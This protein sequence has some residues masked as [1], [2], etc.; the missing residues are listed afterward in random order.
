MI[1]I[2]AMNSTTITVSERTRKELLRVAAELQAKRG[3]KVGYEEVIQYLLTRTRRN[4]E[5]LK[6]ATAPTGVTSEE[7]QRT[8]KEGRAE[9]RR[10]EEELERRYS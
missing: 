6:I 7:L 2:E 4:P 1:P 8:L 5:L 3:E 10:H 9:D